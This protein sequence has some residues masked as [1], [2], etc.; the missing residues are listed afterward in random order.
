VFAPSRR[1]DR[2]A[3]GDVGLDGECTVAEL[4]GERLDAV[5]AARQ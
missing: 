1:G 2:V 3:V 5:G 4:G